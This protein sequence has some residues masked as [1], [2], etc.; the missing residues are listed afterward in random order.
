MSYAHPTTIGMRAAD[1]S[2][3]LRPEPDDARLL[4]QRRELIAQRPAAVLA[5]LPAAE[6]GVLE[7]GQY[8]SARDGWSLP[9][10]PM[11]IL[12]A[13][14]TRYAEDICVLTK[15]DGHHVLSGG[16]LCFPNRWR[17]TDKAG[18]PV[19]AV[20]E[21]VPEYAEKLSAQ[22]DF[23]LDRLRPGRCFR[24]SNW[25]LVST[26]QL[27]LPDPVPPVNP[28][29]DKDFFVRHEGQSFVKLPETGAVIFTIRTTLTRWHDVPPQHR[30]DIL[31][32]VGALT[33][34]WLSYKSI[35]R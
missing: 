20:H 12:R 19:L 33:P 23:F 10:A 35:E 15:T 2:D 28:A 17:L 4:T 7:L 1:L 9:Q 25:G 26:D 32:Q 29:I 21:P 30:A 5:L 34:E 3:W 24:R 11:D 13:L 27:H 8:L 18:K 6:T 31:E 22:V 16:A 14:G